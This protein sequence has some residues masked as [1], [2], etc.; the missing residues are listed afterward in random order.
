MWTLCGFSSGIT[1]HADPKVPRNPALD[2]AV[3][4]AL[5]ASA[6]EKAACRS[7]CSRIEGQPCFEM[8]GRPDE[9]L[10]AMLA[11]R[12][13]PHALFKLLAGAACPGANEA[14]QWAPLL[15]AREADNDGTAKDG[16]P[17]SAET[18][19]DLYCIGSEVKVRANG[20]LKDPNRPVHLTCDN[21]PSSGSL[22]EHGTLIRVELDPPY[23]CM[24]ELEAPTKSTP[25][26]MVAVL[27]RD[28]V[29][30]NRTCQNCGAVYCCSG[31]HVAALTAGHAAGICLGA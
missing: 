24:V 28:V 13:V 22:W 8:A 29:L 11:S 25:T 16:R 2:N 3:A 9:T 4:V 12:S 6:C 26:E 30:T 31:C 15:S 10:E 21:V 1:S 18:I 17:L 14:T 20:V 5:M 23:R 19:A 7:A 27:A